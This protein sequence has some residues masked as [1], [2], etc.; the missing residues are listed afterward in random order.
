[1]HRALDILELVEMICDHLQSEPKRLPD[2]NAFARTCKFFL[3]PA[4]DLMWEKQYVLINLV[5]CMP[6]DLWAETAEG[7]HSV[8]NLLRPITPADW[9]RPLIYASRI[10]HFVLMFP[11]NMLSAY[12][13]ETLSL[14][15]PREQLFPNLETIA[16]APRT[17]QL[18]PYIRLFLGPKIHGVV[19]HYPNS[20][21]ALSLLPALSLKYPALKLAKLRADI[22]DDDDPQLLLDDDELKLRSISTFVRGLTEIIS[23]DLDIIDQGA[24]EHLGRLT[25]LRFLNIGELHR[26]EPSNSLPRLSFPALATLHFRDTR[27]ELASAYI[28]MLSESKLAM[29]DVAITAPATTPT[30]T[31]FYATLTINCPHPDLQILEVQNTEWY[32]QGIADPAHYVVP[33]ASLRLLCCFPNLVVLR[34]Q[35]PAGFDLDDATVWA[36]ARAWPRLRI[37][38]LTADTDAEHHPSRVSLDALCAFAQHCPA[39]AHLSI[40]LDAVAVPPV[41]AASDRPIQTCLVMLNVAAS[42]IST[43][44]HVAAFI[45]KLFP[46]L[47]ALIAHTEEEDEDGDDGDGALWEQ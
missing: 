34:L 9:E 30:T 38:S 37:L 5:K 40:T 1:M 41:E 36:L 23:L 14:C 42:P 16:W 31:H 44:S 10:K 39:L 43:P 15:I 11:H 45:S 20:I 8:F 19:F 25:T 24:F 13:F 27:L 47:L 46:T 28:G 6:S 35:S 2:L 21:S 29:L 33:S 3:F 32:S 22:P 12:V 17:Q 26:L 4:L 7:E 18:Y